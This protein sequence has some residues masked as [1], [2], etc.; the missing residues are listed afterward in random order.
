MLF[1]EVKKTGKKPK[2]VLKC[3]VKLNTFFS[4]S[5]KVSKRMP[6]SAEA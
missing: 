1:A 2:S 6:L 5:E 4:L 3:L